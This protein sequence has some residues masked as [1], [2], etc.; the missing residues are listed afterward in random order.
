MLG[1]PAN[2]D[3]EM[4][5]WR[6]TLRR[7]PRNPG[8]DDFQ[9][10]YTYGMTRP[11]TQGFKDDGFTKELSGKWTTDMAVGHNCEKLKWALLS[12]TTGR[13]KADDL[14][15]GRL[16]IPRQAHIRSRSGGIFGRR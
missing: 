3:C 9:L 4:I 12:I 8:R 1:I 16:A 6:L 2:L 7:D 5:K 14:S 13:R 11:G 10:Q 15:M